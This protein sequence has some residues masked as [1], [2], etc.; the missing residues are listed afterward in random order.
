ML[1][2]VQEDITSS[3]DMV[4]YCYTF[5]T[6]DTIAANSM[7]SLSRSSVILKNENNEVEKS[8]FLS[9]FNYLMQLSWEC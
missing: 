8:I 3:M 2:I 4:Q 9:G 1:F 6:G 7:F 5:F